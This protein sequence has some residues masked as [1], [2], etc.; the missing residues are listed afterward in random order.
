MHVRISAVLDDISIGGHL[1]DNCVIEKGPGRLGSSRVEV[2]DVV[3]VTEA[4]DA[5]ELGPAR[6]NDGVAVCKH[7]EVEVIIE[8]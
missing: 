3:H 1:L 4:D 8:Q 6:G 5:A 7:V 2:S